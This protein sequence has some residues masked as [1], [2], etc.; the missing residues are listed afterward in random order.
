MRK[1]LFALC[2]IALASFA[3]ASVIIVPP[4]SIPIAV[5]P[6]V[7]PSPTSEATATPAPTATPQPTFPSTGNFDTVVPL[8]LY[9]DNGN[10]GTSKTIN[11]TSG[12]SQQ[13]VTI[14]GNCTFTF[15]APP[16]GG[17][18]LLNLVLVHEASS[19]T[20]TLT[21]PNTVKWPGGTKIANTNTS[22]AVDIMHCL[23]TSN[24]PTYYC[25]GSVD[26]R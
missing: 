6:T 10:S 24:T 22:G 11:W 8:Y 16:A 15:T 18:S 1:L 14:T 21:W 25:F 19:T 12:G 13:T 20:Y 23:Y 17:V 26:L 2:L 7:Q 9:T 5:T 3:N 4:G